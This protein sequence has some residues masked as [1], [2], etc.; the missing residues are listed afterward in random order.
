MWPRPGIAAIV[1]RN[2]QDTDA[3]ANRLDR[4]NLALFLDIGVEGVVH[5]AQRRVID[6]RRV[7]LGLR[8]GVEEI[9]LE[10]IERLEA[11]E[12][13]MRRGPL[14]QG[15]MRLGPEERSSFPALGG[16]GAR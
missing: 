12:H 7:G 4:L 9:R 11:D 6:P 1:L 10:A 14:G 3:P 13:A 15:A 16:A 2:V 8:H 5:D